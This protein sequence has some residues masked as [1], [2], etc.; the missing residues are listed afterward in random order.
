MFCP[1]CKTEYRP[2]F[3]S[4]S[5]C[6]AA[7]AETS[8]AEVRKFETPTSDFESDADTRDDP[9]RLWAGSNARVRDA[10]RAALAA[11]EIPFIDEPSPRLVYSSLRPAMEIWVSSRHR[12]AAM[13]IRRSI[14]GEAEDSS[15]GISSVASGDESNVAFN[16]WGYAPPSILDV[17]TG[18]S[19]G[20]QS[21]PDRLSRDL[22]DDGTD[23]AAEAAGFAATPDN[24]FRG[25]FF[26]EDAI[27][28]VYS[29][30]F[31]VVENLAAC[32]REN[33]I[34]SA[35]GKSEG[36]DTTVTL[37]V[38]PEHEARAKEIIREIVEATP[39]E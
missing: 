39:P 33:G 22:S 18:R 6:G 25:Q 35:T 21:E 26:P 31:A 32:L 36:A 38:L 4:C 3:T 12:N 17:V 7:L 29:G 8:D 14:T 19:P 11:E 20:T 34:P 15:G 28:E 24:I 9:V 2:G 1:N 23:P 10:F 13:K 16:L 5:D 30:D 27:A 37:R